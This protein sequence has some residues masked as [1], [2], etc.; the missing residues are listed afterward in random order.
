MREMS[1]SE[2]SLGGLHHEASLQVQILEL[3]TESG[4]ALSKPFLTLPLGS[5]SL[6][7]FQPTAALQEKKRKQNK[8]DTR[9]FFFFLEYF[10]LI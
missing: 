6:V 8:T 4:T 9:V 10:Y 7:S 3:P 1:G 2:E 5:S